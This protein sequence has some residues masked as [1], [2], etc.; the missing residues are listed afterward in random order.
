MNQIKFYDGKIPKPQDR[1]YAENPDCEFFVAMDRTYWNHSKQC[2]DVTKVYAGFENHKAFLKWSAQDIRYEKCFYEM[3]KEDK[4]CVEFYDIDGTYDNDIYLG[5]KGE[6]LTDLQAAENFIDARMQFQESIL[7]EYSEQRLLRR[8]DF[9]IA[10]TP[11]KEGEEKISLHV[12]IR[13]S[14]HFKN[15]EH[16]KLFT[17]KFRDYIKS[18][19]LKADF[20][21]IYTKNRP[22]RML[23]HHKLGQPTRI[24]Q[25]LKGITEFCDIANEELFCGTY[26]IDNTW[27]FPDIEKKTRNVKLYDNDEEMEELYPKSDLGKLVNLITESLDA[28]VN[29]MLCDAEIQDRMNYDKWRTVVFAIF[30][31]CKDENEAVIY[32]QKIA[33][34]Y[35]HVEGMKWANNFETEGR[36]MWPY[37]REDGINISYLHKAAR[38][39]DGYDDNFKHIKARERKAFVRKNYKMNVEE[40]KCMCENS[41]FKYINQIPS[42]T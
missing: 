3:F 42:L 23:G 34:Y 14:V 33:P 13:N 12:I 24:A 35:R 30:S 22:F 10:T 21:K 8:S 4:K 5:D 29:D 6:K 19:N 27:T 1:C 20:D 16:L 31:A 40:A 39:N 17:D 32:F 7:C 11:P 9:L 15:I 2:E 38:Y 18:N 25:R 28:R 26:V 37:L 41:K 36:R